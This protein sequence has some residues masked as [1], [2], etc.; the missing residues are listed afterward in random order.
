MK[1]AFGWWWEQRING[2]EWDLGF[3]VGYRILE[4]CG[5]LDVVY[6]LEVLLC[7]QSPRCQ[8]IS[9]SVREGM[10][11]WNSLKARSIADGNN[12]IPW[13]LGSLLLDSR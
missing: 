7:A 2:W 4:L 5:I 12:N 1:G 9:D 11:T 8:K 13:R 3:M 10:L 6:M